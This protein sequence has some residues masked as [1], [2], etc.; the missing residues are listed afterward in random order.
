MVLT[1]VE[2]H[3]DA[4][5][6]YGLHNAIWGLARMNVRLKDLSP[7]LA[8]AMFSRTILMLHTFQS[9]QYG[10]LMWSLG[11][12]GYQ[13]SDMSREE[14]D[15]LLA[16]VSRIFGKLHVRAAAYVLW[17]F[18]KMGFTW[19]DLK[20]RTCSLAGCCLLPTYTLSSVMAA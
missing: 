1:T 3:L 7:T 14:R 20:Q 18:G 2:Q 12:I 17:G 6:I 4:F 16:V 10:D 19:T 5:N 11:S 13:A 8:K 15:R 9:T